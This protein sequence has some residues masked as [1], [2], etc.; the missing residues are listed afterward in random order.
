MKGNDDVTAVQTLKV[1]LGA[2]LSA[3]LVGGALSMSPV[4]ASAADKPEWECSGIRCTQ[5]LNDGRYDVG[6]VYGTSVL[7]D[8]I[9]CY[10]H[11]SWCRATVWR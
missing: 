8:I 10:N 2:T 5:V 3:S 11:A 7:S 4:T 1:I 9:K 6:I